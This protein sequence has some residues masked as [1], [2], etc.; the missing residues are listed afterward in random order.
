MA[1]CAAP[2]PS[3]SSALQRPSEIAIGWG[4]HWP[5]RR[6]PRNRLRTAPPH[7]IDLIQWEW[8]MKYASAPMETP[9]RA[10]QRGRLFVDSSVRRQL[11]GRRR[12]RVASTALH[13]PIQ[14]GSSW[15]SC[16]RS[17]DLPHR[18]TT[19]PNNT[20]HCER[21]R[22]LTF[23]ESGTVCFTPFHGLTPCLDLAPP[24]DLLN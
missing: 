23:W 17:N 18:Q 8:S 21:D 6:L 20:P 19:S 5:A 15:K 2:G 1:V 7:H 9:P 10:N 24:H 11:A 4:K 22:G 13:N 12:F 14:Q 16:S 3:W